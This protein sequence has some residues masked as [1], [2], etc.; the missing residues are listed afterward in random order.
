MYQQIILRLNKLEKMI[1]FINCEYKK[2]CEN[3][4]NECTIGKWSIVQNK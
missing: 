4:N 2:C 3:S 1:K